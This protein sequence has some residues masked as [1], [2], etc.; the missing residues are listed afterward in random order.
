MSPLGSQPRIRCVR[1]QKLSPQGS[2][3]YSQGVP[4]GPE[5]YKIIE[6]RERVRSGGP[7][8]RMVRNTETNQFHTISDYGEVC[9]SDEEHCLQCFYLNEKTCPVEDKY[10]VLFK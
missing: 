4:L 1:C 9:P 5:C 8:S 3:K 6:F 7:N 2:I 10:G